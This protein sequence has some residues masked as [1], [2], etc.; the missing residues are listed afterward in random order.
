MPE[1]NSPWR[2]IAE[3]KPPPFEGARNPVVLARDK[4]KLPYLVVLVG[5]EFMLC[6][7]MPIYYGL[8]QCGW[9][10]VTGLVDFMEIPK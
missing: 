10:K 6:P 3:Y 2:P 7:G 9:W 4:E 8:N 5:S 1:D